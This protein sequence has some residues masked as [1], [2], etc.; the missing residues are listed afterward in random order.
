MNK[1]K[2][3]ILKELKDKFE[4]FKK[5]AGFKATYEEINKFSYFEDAAISTGF[6]SERETVCE[7]V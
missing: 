5:E 7:C 2:Q 1:D 3:D 4:S 6:V